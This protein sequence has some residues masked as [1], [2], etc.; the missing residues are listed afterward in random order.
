M[1]APAAAVAE[2][3]DPNRSRHRRSSCG[4]QA[5]PGREHTSCGRGVCVETPSGAL[6]GLARARARVR[7]EEDF[8][9]PAPTL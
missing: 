6:R 4:L 2:L 8:A 5:E 9:E 1:S 3:M 7:Q